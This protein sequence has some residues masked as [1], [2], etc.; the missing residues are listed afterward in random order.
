MSAT[1]ARRAQLVEPRRA[2]SFSNHR[3]CDSLQ[4]GS[5]PEASESESP[6][7]D[8]CIVTC[9]DHSGRGSRSN[10][11]RAR[12][13]PADQSGSQAD[14]AWTGS[15]CVTTTNTELEGAVTRCDS[16]SQPCGPI[17]RRARSRT[18]WAWRQALPER[19]RH[20]SYLTLPR[21]SRRRAR[22]VTAFARGAGPSVV[23]D[24]VSKQSWLLKLK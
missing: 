21:A 16:E 9:T 8:N 22:S 7:W 5:Q 11:A 15:Q 12:G 18:Y 19:R 23:V 6:G 20:S 14:T 17:D 3:D 10:P 24:T 1:W 13:G 2:V 4:V